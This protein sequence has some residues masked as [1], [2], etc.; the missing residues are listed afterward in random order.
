MRL[1]YCNFLKLSVY[2]SAIFV[3]ILIQVNDHEVIG[4][5]ICNFSQILLT[6]YLHQL[7]ILVF[8]CFFK[9]L[10]LT[11]SHILSHELIIKIKVILHFLNLIHVLSFQ[12]ILKFTFFCNELLN[13]LMLFIESFFFFF[14]EIVSM[15]D[16]KVKPLSINSI[17]HAKITNNK[18]KS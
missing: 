5:S 9:Q 17:S 13:F 10:I 8:L 14:G 4:I 3:A 11:L 15:F 1:F 12:S 6:R 18:I 16:L 7:S 2:Q